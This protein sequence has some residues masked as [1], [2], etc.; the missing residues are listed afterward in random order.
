M[1]GNKKSHT[2][3]TADPEPK[4]ANESAAKARSAVLGGNNQDEQRRDGSGG[5]DS[6]TRIEPACE[7]RNLRQR[8]SVH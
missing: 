4:F 2:P 1:W 3:Q 7:R 5:S 8:G 6:A